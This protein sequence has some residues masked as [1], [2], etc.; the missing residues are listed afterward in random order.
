MRRSVYSLLLFVCGTPL[1]KILA[2]VSVFVVSG[3]GLLSID[4]IARRFQEVANRCF[5]GFLM[6]LLDA[7]KYLGWEPSAQ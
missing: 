6:F 3:S 5:G 4:M 2:F 7:V 1:L